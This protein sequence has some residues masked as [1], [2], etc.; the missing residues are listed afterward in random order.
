M[1][2]RAPASTISNVPLVAL[3]DTATGPPPHG[4]LGGLHHRGGSS[5][6]SAR[7]RSVDRFG[8]I[9]TSWPARARAHVS[10][11]ARARIKAYLEVELDFSLD[12]HCA[13]PRVS[14]SASA[15]SRTL[16]VRGNRA[17]GRSATHKV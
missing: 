15:E 17:P 9:S 10:K 14:C 11:R 1:P 7:D 3:L 8:R 6:T 2:K 13:S 5:L 16:A 4:C 12:A